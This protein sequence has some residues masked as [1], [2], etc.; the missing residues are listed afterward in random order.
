[1]IKDEGKISNKVLTKMLNKEI[2][3]LLE[4]FLRI[5][6]KDFSAAKDLVKIALRQRK[7]EKIRCKYEEEGQHV[8]PF[9]IA[10]ITSSCNLNCKGCYDKVKIHNR[11]E[12]L[13]DIKWIDIFTEAR[14]LGISFILLAGGEPLTKDKVIK[15]CVNFPEIIFPVFTNGLLIDEAYTDYFAASRN[16]IP[17]ISI[18][19]DS[20]QTDD[21]R[22]KGVFDRVSMSFELLKKRNILFGTSITLTS[23]N[24]DTVLN[25]AF[26][27]DQI[28][29]GC[30]IFFFIEYV[31]FDNQSKELVI[32]SQQRINIDNTINELKQKYRGIFISF[33]GDEKIFGGCLAAGR[34]FVHINSTGSLE[35][36]PFA[37]YSDTNLKKMKLREALNSPVL[38]EIRE[39]HEVLKDHKGG[40]ALF[41]NK[42]L[43]D[44]K[45]KGEI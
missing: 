15:A 5:A 19:G 20:I 37:P 33:P 40:C 12:E 8:P 29:R 43:V 27:K 32:S 1:M 22:G 44:K 24:I 42:S 6:F 9:M 25:E 21:R 26:I 16:V 39:L 3:I 10:S 4:D 11:L 2:R 38:S 23:D 17:V 30:R 28:D 41:D 34:G 7:S 45:L 35:A 18:E 36:C 13:E 14:E 31:P